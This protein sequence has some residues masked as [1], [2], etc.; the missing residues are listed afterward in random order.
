MKNIL[1]IAYHF[2]PI[3]VS[4]GIQRT[5]KFCRYL[6]DHNWRSLVLTVHPRAY[7]AT[8]DSQLKDIPAQIVV[9]RAF[10]LDS[11][12]HLAIKGRYFS[13]LALPDRWVSWCLG[14]VV[15][16]LGLIRRY[17]PMLIFST[18]PIASSHLLG[19]WLHR[20]TKLP[21]V[22]DF[23]DSMTEPGYP[24]HPW[25]KKFYDWLEQRTIQHCARAI[26]TTSG[27]IRMYQQRY[28]N[29]CAKKWV[30]IANGYD[31]ENFI[32]AE[33]SVHLQVFKHA[34][35]PGQTVLLHS[36]VLYPSER[37]PS[38]LLQ[39]LVELKQAG[40]IDE[41]NFKLVL[42]ATGHDDY[43][44]PLLQCMDLEDVVSLAPNVAYETALAEM[45]AVDG[46][47][48]L[49]ASNCNH[50]VPAKIYEY[51]RAK[52]PIL[53]LTDPVGDTAAVLRS[54]GLT[55]ITPLDDKAAIMATLLT[56]LQQLNNQT[57]EVAPYTT[58]QA[59]SRQAQTQLLA[60][61][62]EEVCQEATRT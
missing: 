37:D 24:S 7:T 32:K 19:L 36:G 17:R 57:F 45:L 60:Q 1:M 23:R 14:G 50:Q 13:G 29:V 27:A 18:Y 16:G 21:W 31:E 61:L 30:L 26:F 20:I 48:V 40:T 55:T 15:A 42:R 59:Y 56:F 62:F 52:R 6:L 47:L 3:R 12:R 34:K 2:P 33:Q 49:Q 58:I 46:L 11:A 53:A 41:A 54:M 35:R 44:A 39:A 43:Y 28:P 4:S 22:A 5:L 25:Q 51:L 8:H 9:K 10:A 38:Q